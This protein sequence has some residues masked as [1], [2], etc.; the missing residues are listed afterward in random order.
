MF[1]PTLAPV[2]EPAGN[3]VS[4]AAASGRAQYLASD[5]VTAAPG[6][7]LVMLYDRLVLDLDRA[8]QAL[9][10]EASPAGTRRRLAR[11]QILHA[12]EIVMELRASLDPNAGWE[13]TAG[14]SNLYGFLFNELVQANISMDAERIAGAR[15][16]AEPLRDAWRQAAMEVAGA[17]APIGAAV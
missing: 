2:V 11:T 7:L 4:P 14:M 9:R 5:V 10:D 16:V 6:K 15:K 13:G 12:Q 3:P 8:E 17:T 1:V